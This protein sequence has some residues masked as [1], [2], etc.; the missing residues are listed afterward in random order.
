[1]CL[2]LHL[3][4]RYIKDTC[5]KNKGRKVKDSFIALQDIQ[6]RAWIQKKN[7]LAV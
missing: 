3:Y 6:Y 5:R 4:E 7:S 1:M 2:Q